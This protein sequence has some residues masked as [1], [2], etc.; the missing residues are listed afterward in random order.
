MHVVYKVNSY[1][2]SRLHGA[3]IAESSTPGHSMP[4]WGLCGMAQPPS[5]VLLPC[6][7]TNRVQMSYCTLNKGLHWVKCCPACSPQ[8]QQQNTSTVPQIPPQASQACQVPRLSLTGQPPSKSS[9]PAQVSLLP[10]SRCSHSLLPS[11]GFSCSRKSAASGWQ[12]PMG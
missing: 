8:Q 2:H 10:P 3:G 7:G 1:L 9:V 12:F 6:N 11:V 5:T 4:S